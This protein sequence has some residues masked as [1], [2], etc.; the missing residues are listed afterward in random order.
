MERKAIKGYDAMERTEQKAS[1][2][3]FPLSNH[4]PC[5]RKVRVK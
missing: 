2:R 1:A 5:K 4:I 3:P